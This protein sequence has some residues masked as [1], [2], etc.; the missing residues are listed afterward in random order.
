[1][2][3]LTDIWATKTAKKEVEVAS[4]VGVSSN[5][6][7]T[8]ILKIIM[9]MKSMSAVINPIKISAKQD[10]MRSKKRVAT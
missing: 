9:M 8:K 6:I 1:L 10:K 5:E 2:I 7:T 3:V 4:K